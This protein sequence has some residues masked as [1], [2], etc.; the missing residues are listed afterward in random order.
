M[1]RRKLRGG[2][3]GSLMQIQALNKGNVMGVRSRK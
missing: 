1:K 3:A 2:I